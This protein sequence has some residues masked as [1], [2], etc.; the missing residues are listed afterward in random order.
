MTYDITGKTVLVTG[1]NRGIGKVLV[2]SFIAN[3]AAKVYAAVRK[4]DSVAALVEQ[5]GDK[6]VPIRLDLLDAPLIQS[7]AQTAR[8]VQIVVSN[9]G[10]FQAM[11]PLEEGAIASLDTLMNVNVYGLIRLA[12][13]FSPILK[14][15]G[16]G[17]F[18]QLN[19]VVSMKTFSDF[20]TYSASKAA[21]YSVTQA[22]REQLAEQGTRVLS[23]HPG[24]IDT[25]MG[26]DAGFV[27]AASPTLVAEALFKAL[28]SSEFHVFPD[29][30]AQQIGSAYQSFASNI[31]EASMS[32]S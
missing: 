8:D 25:D 21:A 2:E 29:A 24:P 15:N 22:L 11:T 13:A 20:T 1:A 18:A 30:M 7:A 16:G 26:D 5:Y 31:V 32:E 28:D 27:E 3:G 12:R 10:A 19:S 14:A 17:V 23:I 6:V 4:I 9:A